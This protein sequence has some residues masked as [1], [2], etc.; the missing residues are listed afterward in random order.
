MSYVNWNYSGKTDLTVGTEA[1]ISEKSI[2]WCASAVGT[3]V[4]GIYW[5]NTQSDWKILHYAIAIA[6]SLDIIGG[7]VANATNSCKR[8]YHSPPRE[9][10]G[11]LAGFLKTGMNFD[12]LHVH[13]IFVGALF[14]NSSIGTGAIWYLGLIASAALV[15]RCPLYLKR[16]VAFTAVMAAVLLNSI[17]FT[18]G[19]GF[20][21]LIPAL[22]IKIVYG[23]GVQE[24]PYRPSDEA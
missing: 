21:W 11:R 3:I 16:P 24:E 4:L 10:E 7:V 9:D 6:L 18:M 2:V 19:S 8:F 15:Y 22:F 5:W 12:L 13:P 17:G 1:T 14:P 20:E 23:H